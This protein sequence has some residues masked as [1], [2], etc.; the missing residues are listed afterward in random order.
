MRDALGSI[1]WGSLL[2]LQQY[3]DMTECPWYPAAQ[4]YKLPETLP[5][6]FGKLAEELL[7]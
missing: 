7:K 5:A 4:V 1:D 3:M 2:G 6:D